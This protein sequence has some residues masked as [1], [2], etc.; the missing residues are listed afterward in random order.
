M[1]NPMYIDYLHAR[2]DGHDD[3]TANRLTGYTGATPGWVLEM[4]TVVEIL[5]EQCNAWGEGPARLLQMKQGW[6]E[7]RV[8]HE[9]EIGRRRARVQEI[10]RRE[11]AVELVLTSRNR[12]VKA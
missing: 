2:M 3:A 6:A 10:A 9:Q 11:R 4:W 8:R 5:V 7:E 1:T 12:D